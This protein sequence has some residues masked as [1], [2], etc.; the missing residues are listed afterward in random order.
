MRVAPRPT[1]LPTCQWCGAAGGDLRRVGDDEHLRPLPQRL[2]PAADGVGGGAADA[3]V[4]LVEDQR[5][6]RRARALR[7]TLSASRKRESSPPEAMRSSGPGGMPGLVA[8]VKDA[9]AAV[10][11][12]L[13]GRDLGGEAGAVELQRRE[14]PA[15]RGV[16]PRRRR[17]SAPRSAPRR[18]PS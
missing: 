12:G 18:R 13:A 7:Q 16:E 11:P 14:L 8:T 5:E 1:D 15:M 4:D 3:A 9:V 10:G 2:Q 17:R 6:A